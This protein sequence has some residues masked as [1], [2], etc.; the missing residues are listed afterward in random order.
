MR[1]LALQQLRR[2]K[3]LTGSGRIFAPIT[4]EFLETALAAEMESHLDEQECSFGNKRDGASK[5]PQGM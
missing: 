5:Y 1:D 2:G 4:K 3:S